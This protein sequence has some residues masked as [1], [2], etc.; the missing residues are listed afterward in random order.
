MVDIILRII[1]KF[2]RFITIN[3]LIIACAIGLFVVVTLFKNNFLIL[4]G[5][6]NYFL[7]PD[8][9]FNFN[10][11]AWKSLES[12]GY[13]NPLINYCFVIFHF[14]AGLWKLGI[15]YSAINLVL[16]HLAYSGPLLSM[17]WLAK[18][19]FRIESFPATL[20]ALFYVLNPFSV[21][22]IQSMMFWNIVPLAFLPIF[23]GI[24]FLNYSSNFK[25]FFY[26]GIACLVTSF[27]FANIPY[28]GIFQ[29][30]LLISLLVIP[31]LKD[32]L[33]RLKEF[34]L[35][36]VIVE[37]SFILFSAWWLINL[38]R[39]Q[40]QDNSIG[41]TKDFAI[42]WARYASGDGRIMQKIFSFKELIPIDK[43]YFLSDFYN[44]WFVN[45]V[46]VMPF[47][48][49]I[50]LFIVE[51]N[52]GII[53]KLSIMVLILSI[54][55]FL[56]KGVNEPFG[57][58]YILMLEKLPLFIIFKSPL[59]KFSLLL[60]VIF[61]MTI[62]I[63]YSS[64]K[65][66]LNVVLVIYLTVAVI[67]FVTLNFIPDFSIGA[68]KFITRKFLYKQE[69]KQVIER[70]NNDKLYYRYLSLPG[71]LNYQVTM[72]N[73]DNKYYR[74]MDPVLYA[75]NKP[76]IATYSGDQFDI[77]YKNLSSQNI[78]NIMGAFSI[79]KI[80]INK[81]II[82]SFGFSEK[83]SSSQLNT[84]FSKTMAK[85]QFGNIDLYD[86]ESYV[87]LI[88]TPTREIYIN[89]PSSGPVNVLSKMTSSD[90]KHGSVVFS[91]NS[92]ES[93]ADK[94]ID[95]P[96]ENRPTIEFKKINEIK[97][98][99]IVHGLKQ[100]IPLIFN[101]SFNKQWK[102]FQIPIQTEEFNL[103]SNFE[104]E[105]IEDGATKDDL[106]NYINE[107]VIS[108]TTNSQGKSNFISKSFNKTIQNDNLLDGKFYETWLKSEIGGNIHSEA[109]G[110][111]NSWVINPK[112]LCG[113]SGK[114][115]INADGSYDTE[116]VVEFWPQRVFYMGSFITGF[117]LIVS[118]VCL[119]FHYQ[120]KCKRRTNDQIIVT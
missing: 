9:L 65:R 82:P 15:S 78:E 77:I 105:N 11:S 49:V 14:I 110:Y 95:F 1:E 36:F 60:L 101:E 41:Y 97:Y 16:A 94:I 19:V 54:I 50:Y 120:H 37:S 4:G 114:C 111:A 39:I 26:S 63:L 80:M 10:G 40:F 18:K 93:T 52:K 100:E 112:E 73:H 21:F 6:G 12:A 47:F 76:F 31:F 3:W 13:P 28:L 85:G 48:L 62:I 79:R 99:V 66:I 84:I 91:E 22:H 42:S 55:I 92:S 103:A 81:D 27:S 106:I 32:K 24:L 72:H 5:E 30:F 45:I 86:L 71:S 104:S 20:I 107:K 58:L 57:S 34:A 29:I 87:P 43:G 118:M 64:K 23:F 51:K 109:N 38:V 117:T 7:N 61:T 102:M 119:V 70:I 88:Y 74:G 113:E 44:N 56:N 2:N 96:D 89:N 59:E 90:F 25:L 53:R 35:K 17:Y 8:V 67:P 68:N 98:R 83:N 46:M 33:F 75:I 108:K 115:T 116:L 69:Y